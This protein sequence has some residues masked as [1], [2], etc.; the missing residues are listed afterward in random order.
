MADTASKPA[1]PLSIVS[2][3]ASMTAVAVGNGM[4]FAY[5][6]FVLSTEKA[7]TWISGAAVTAVA[8]GG[9]IG[10][11]IAGPLIRRVGHARLFAC[12][13]ALV[14]LSAVIIAFGVHPLAWVFARGLYGCAGN[15]NFI[16]SQSWLNHAAANSWRGKAMSTFYMAYV[17]GM[18]FGAWL[19]G[20]IPAAGNI[21]PLVT[22]AFTALA[23]L[24]IGLTRL[25]T[26][27]AP[28]RV[29][30]DIALAWKNS[31]VGL[32]GVLAAGGL[33]MAVQGFTPI[34]AAAD[35]AS[36]K[37]VALLMFVMQFGLIA[38]QYPMGTLSDRIDRRIVLIATCL[39]I[40]LISV[41]ALGVPFSRLPLLMLVFA[42]FAGSVETV[43][44]IANAH[45]NDRTEPGDFVSLSSTLLVAWST[46]ATVI[47]LGITLLTP[48]FG[49]QTFIYAAMAVSLAYAGFVAF[50]LYGRPEN[51]IGQGEG[52]ELMSAQVP[53]AGALVE[54][55]EA[56]DAHP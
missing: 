15:T 48:V 22:V 12:S 38:I 7:P 46:A 19:F 35:G 37:D 16:I 53:N 31:P 9:L 17:F 43:Y 18:G 20:E 55:D 52:F 34:Y 42:I 21:A 33:S 27:P 30:I 4:M 24:P 14:I 51:V 26:P 2:I 13:M 1:S 10:C 41:V 6:P 54:D 25:P 29:S 8:L 56:G 36:Q 49:P 3:V 11:V 50:R 32:I 5:V 23:I 47:P 45:A 40:A 44:S 39:I 28:A